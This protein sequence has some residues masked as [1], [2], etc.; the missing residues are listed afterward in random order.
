[1][2]DQIAIDSFYWKVL[3]LRCQI[4]DRTAFEELVAHCQPRLHGFLWKMVAD[5]EKANELAQEVW[6]DVFRDLPKLVNPAAFQPWLYRIAR[7]RVFRM[8]RRRDYTINSLAD[9]DVPAADDASITFDSDDAEVVHA[10]LAQLPPQHREVVVL[11]F[12]E[13]LSYQDIAGVVGCQVGTVKSRLYK[14]KRML[15]KILERGGS[16]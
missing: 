10:A 4:G 5:R 3:V 14:A 13:N 12:I 8:L 11:R 16:K 7:N 9:A 2:A 15:R 1:M 6:M